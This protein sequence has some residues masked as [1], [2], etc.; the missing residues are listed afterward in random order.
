MIK[1]SLMS[2]S[3]LL[4]AGFSTTPKYL[5]NNISEPKTPSWHHS[6]KVVARKIRGEFYL[7]GVCLNKFMDDPLVTKMIRQ[8]LVNYRILSESEASLVAPRHVRLQKNSSHALW[9]TDG[10]KGAYSKDITWHVEPYSD[11]TTWHVDDHFFHFIAYF[12]PSNYLW[13][14]N[15]LMH[16][17]KFST[18]E[19]I[20]GCLM[21]VLNDNHFSSS[22][23][24]IP[25][26]DS[27][28]KIFR[29]NNRLE[30][31]MG[32]FGSWWSNESETINAVIN[33]EYI[34]HPQHEVNVCKNIDILI[35]SL[36]YFF[37][38]QT[39]KNN[40]GMMLNLAWYYN[41]DD[42]VM[43]LQSAYIW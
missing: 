27:L 34:Y 35:H 7:K 30:E 14:R 38:Y 23:E 33:R 3:L 9:V 42:N 25:W 31:H 43:S 20:L 2:S 37:N 5:F 29:W 12:T 22:E 1:L 18:D 36:R 21:Q 24:N 17:L 15:L 40:F 19:W 32:H 28:T 8:T 13:L 26:T 16:D 10:K 4:F 6:V 11:I 39:T 41:S